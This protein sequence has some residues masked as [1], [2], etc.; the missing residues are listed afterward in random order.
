MCDR[1]DFMGTVGE[2]GRAGR[3]TGSYTNFVCFGTQQDLCVNPEE[4]MPA[5]FG[6]TV[7]SSQGNF[8]E[9]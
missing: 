8:K 9:S 2:R 7:E 3:T 1:A 6:P 4:H 5:R